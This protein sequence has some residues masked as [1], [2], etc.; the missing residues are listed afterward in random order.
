MATQYICY[1]RVSTVRQGQSGLGLE[2]QRA[3][4]ENFL[5]STE[6]VAIA[7]FTE[8]ESGKHANRPQLIQAIKACRD[9]GATLLIAKLDRLA[10]NVHF[11]SG[12]LES[13][14]KFT[15]IDMP[16]ADRFMLHV[17]AAM[18]EEEG[19][20]IS[21]RTKAALASAK[22]RGVRLGTYGSV[23]AMQHKQDA[24]ERAHEVK[25]VLERLIRVDC[26]TF[27]KAAVRLNELQVPTA[28]GKGWHATTVYRVWT[29][30]QSLD[31]Q[32]HIRTL[33]SASC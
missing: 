25:S 18:A 9:I 23:L 1:Y 16:N 27:E 2:A 10:R 28:K 21:E 31:T 29:R 13:G 4:T 5:R 6:G 20:R 32:D 33:A 7:D 26:L 24:L 19:R 30:I 11:I 12:L 22:A 15:A 8:V 14:V 3:A 17:Y